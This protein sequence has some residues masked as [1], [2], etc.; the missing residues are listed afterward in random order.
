[1]ATSPLNVHA[2]SNS[3]PSR[4]HPIT[5]QIDERLNQLRESQSTSASSSIGHQLNR[6]QDLY[7]SVDMLLQLPHSR[8]ALAQEQQKKLVEQLL[9]GSL[10]YETAKDALLQ[11][12]KGSLQG[13]APKTRSRED[14]ETGAVSRTLKQV[15]AL[16]VNVLESLLSFILGPEAASKSSPWSSH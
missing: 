8:Q 13:F 15:E 12:K 14:V 7:E 6:L 11:L 3:L 9:D 5:S 16:T 2:R 10:I 1:M 4:Q